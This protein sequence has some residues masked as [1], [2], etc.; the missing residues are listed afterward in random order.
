MVKRSNEE[1]DL[2]AARFEEW[3]DSVEPDEI[4]HAEAV[5]DLREVAEA[6]DAVA[7]AQARVNEAVI[8]ARAHGHSWGR[9]GVAL[10][11]SR[12]AARQRFGVLEEAHRG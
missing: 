1:L 3:A 10:G 12:Q 4:K 6:A 2:A 11:M 5:A 9:I 8:V 7:A